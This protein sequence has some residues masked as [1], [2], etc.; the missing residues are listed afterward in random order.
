[1]LKLSAAP[2]TFCIALS[3][4]VHWHT[5]LLYWGTLYNFVFFGFKF[6]QWWSRAASRADRYINLNA[7]IWLPLFWR[8]WTLAQTSTCPHVLACDMGR[9]Y[10]YCRASEL[11]DLQV[12]GLVFPLISR[13]YRKTMA[14]SE[15]FLRIMPSTEVTELYYSW[16]DCT[17]SLV[18]SGLPRVPDIDE[19]SADLDDEVQTIHHTLQVTEFLLPQGQDHIC[20][21]FTCLLSLLHNH[22]IY[23]TKQS[24][25]HST[26]THHLENF[27]KLYDS[28]RQRKLEVFFLKV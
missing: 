2:W 20:I 26:L 21:F 13:K 5:Q 22:H 6:R 17:Y 14:S 8:T 28:I 7:T 10:I 9:H 27:L 19:V 4:S 24:C 18:L 15:T 16:N 11:T 3:Q 25:N 1:M 12:F 23:Y